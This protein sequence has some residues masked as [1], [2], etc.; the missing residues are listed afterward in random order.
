MQY[1]IF[2]LRQLKRISIGVL[3][4]PCTGDQKYEELKWESSITP[5]KIK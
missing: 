4:C 2:K 3:T 5:D 1:S